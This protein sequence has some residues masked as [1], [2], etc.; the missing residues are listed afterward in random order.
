MIESTI[1]AVIHF[2]AS[3]NNFFYTKVSTLAPGKLA[4]IGQGTIVLYVV[5]LV[6]VVERWSCMIMAVMSV[7]V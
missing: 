7:V 5:E 6:S 3:D 4:I 1:N 2:T